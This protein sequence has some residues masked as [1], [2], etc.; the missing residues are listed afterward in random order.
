MTDASIEQEYDTYNKQ[1]G[2]EAFSNLIKN[3]E[4]VAKL[5][6]LNELGSFISMISDSEIAGQQSDDYYLACK[7]FEHELENQAKYL[8]KG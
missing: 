2:Y 6:I 1:M 5:K 3:T 8:K 4:K 7:H